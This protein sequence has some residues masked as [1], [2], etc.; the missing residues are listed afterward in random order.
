MLKIVIPILTELVDSFCFVVKKTLNDALG[1]RNVRNQKR[2][3]IAWNNYEE[4]KKIEN[5]KVK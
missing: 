3:I 5:Q 1:T 2:I 4:I